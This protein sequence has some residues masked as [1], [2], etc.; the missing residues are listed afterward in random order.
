MID[1]KH[2]VLLALAACGGTAEL[3]YD[4]KTKDVA[5]SGPAHFDDVA[6]VKPSADITGPAGEYFDF[7]CSAVINQNEP[8]KVKLVVGGGV[9]SGSSGHINVTLDFD[10]LWWEL[11]NTT[12]AKGTVTVAIDYKHT[13]PADVGRQVGE[14]AKHYLDSRR[15]KH[16]AVPVLAGPATQ[17]AVGGTIACS[18]HEDGSVHCWGQQADP[19]VGPV[20]SKTTITKAVEVAASTHQ[21]CARLEGGEVK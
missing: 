13:S 15:P 1:M 9:P 7:I 10:V 2:L 12:H 16:A 20:P 19:I 14:M 8:A 6:D 11:P 5:E 17:V 21:A 4:L 18:L 3:K